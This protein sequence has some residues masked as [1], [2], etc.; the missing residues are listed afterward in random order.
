MSVQSGGYTRG[1]G[2]R[3]RRADTCARSGGCACWGCALVVVDISILVWCLGR[4][5]I[6][7]ELG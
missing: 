5:I 2:Y 6:Y 4:Q 3:Y 1:G 7:L